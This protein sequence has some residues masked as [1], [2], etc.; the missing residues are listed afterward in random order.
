MMR[1]EVK[2]SFLWNKALGRFQLVLLLGAGV[3]SCTPVTSAGVDH[4]SV[5]FDLTP[6]EEWL[7]FTSSGGGIYVMNV[8]SRNV[9]KVD[10]QGH[11]ANR[12]QI[13]PDGKT[14]AFICSDMEKG[15]VLCTVP[16]QGGTMNRLTHDAASSD[17]WP[18]FA[19]DGKSIAFARAKK[20]RAYSMGGETWDD[21]DL[22]IVDSDGKGL[23]KITSS[24]Y[25]AVSGLTFWLQEGQIVFSA[26][27]HAAKT[28]D[29]TLLTVSS[30][31]KEAPRELFPPSLTK[32]I[33]DP[34]AWSGYAPVAG[35]GDSLAF[36]SGWDA[37]VWL[38]QPQGRVVKRIETSQNVMERP[39]FAKGG[40]MYY[41]A[42]SGG[43][44]SNVPVYALWSVEAGRRAVLVAPSTFFTRP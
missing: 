7:A 25:Y 19:P 23:R 30:L 15:G 31:A 11:H 35:P 20:C 42:D 39:V 13:S 29:P 21:Y 5:T 17:C 38:F 4:T 1:V 36:V 44:S 40:K 26:T 14:L 6:D 27:P 18:A 33:T 8:P 9:T 24:A 28:A 12:V 22:W 16:I 10:L 3:S 41:F 43:G 37:R 34:R 32:S 2:R